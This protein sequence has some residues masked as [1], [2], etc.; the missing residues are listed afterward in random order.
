MDA[1][2]P[3]DGLASPSSGVLP[4][5]HAALDVLRGLTIMFMILVNSP[6]SWEHVYAPLRHATWHGMTP[7]DLVFPLF[8]F[9]VGASL[10]LSF[11][12]STTSSPNRRMQKI[13][14]KAVILF[15]I[16]LLLHWFPF[17]NSL[18]DLRIMGVLQ[19]IALCTLFASALLLYC[20]QR[21]YQLFACGILLGYQCCYLMG[22]Y[23]ASLSLLGNPV[24]Q[25]DIL[26]FG[27]EHLWQGF[28]L[29]FDPEGLLSTIPAIVNVIIGFECMRLYQKGK[30]RELYLIAVA[31]LMLG[32]L[33][34]FLFPVNKSLWTSS[35]VLFSSGLCLLLFLGVTR[36]HIYVQFSKIWT[37]FLVF[38]MN[39][40]FLYALSWLMLRTVD[41][42]FVSNEKELIPLS[43]Y[44]FNLMSFVLANELAS[45]LYSLFNMAFAGIV[46][47][48]LYQY[49]IFIKI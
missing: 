36:L 11:A 48:V 39:P 15:G 14:K 40:L 27:E 18:S 13:T 12:K 17:Q 6:G 20:S 21:G 45:F 23:A 26:V 42:I 44:L 25:F 37:P 9:I 41:L 10:Y 29:A 19:R 33:W 28:G 31:F 16:G 5:R 35:Y 46:G 8:L 34:H 43:V 47:F 49:R 38:G 3:V 22:D 7:T 30:V 24:R 4:Y 2:V 32:G 1:S